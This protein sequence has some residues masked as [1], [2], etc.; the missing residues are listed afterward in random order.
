MD[1]RRRGMVNNNLYAVF[2]RKVANELERQGFRVVKMEKNN[3]NEKYIVYYFNDTVE[4]RD[5]LRPLI[6]K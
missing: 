4:F 3:K 1:L 2:S 5:A 6:T